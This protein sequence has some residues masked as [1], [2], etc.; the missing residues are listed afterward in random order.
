MC[1]ATH[2]KKGRLPAAACAAGAE[3]PPLHFRSAPAPQAAAA[4]QPAAAASSSGGQSKKSKKKKGKK[5]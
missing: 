5:K 4:V 2:A 3:A 1:W